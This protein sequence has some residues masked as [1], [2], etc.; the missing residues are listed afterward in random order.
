MGTISVGNTDTAHYLKLTRNVYRFS[1]VLEETA[2]GAHTVDERIDVQA[3]LGGIKF[4]Y[5]LIRNMD[6][7]TG[8]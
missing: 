3:H 5:E 7:Y 1:P 4:Y 2:R 6:G 8:E